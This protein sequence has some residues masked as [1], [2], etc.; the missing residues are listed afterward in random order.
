MV[1]QAKKATNRRGQLFFLSERWT[2]SL[3]AS[4][5]LDRGLRRARVYKQPSAHMLWPLWRW[6]PLAL[7]LFGHWQALRVS[8][9]FGA[10]RRGNHAAA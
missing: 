8:G 1:R 3:R 2:A 10:R 6:D 7:D 4:R 5:W 9:V